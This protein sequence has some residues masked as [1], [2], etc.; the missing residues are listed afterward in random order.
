MRPFFP[1]SSSLVPFN[2][3]RVKLEGFFC[4]VFKS[5][6]Y[7]KIYFLNRNETLSSYILLDFHPPDIQELISSSIH[8]P[9]IYSAPTLYWHHH[10]NN[11]GK[12]KPYCRGRQRKE[13]LKHLSLGEPTGHFRKHGMSRT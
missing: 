4:F 13:E 7:D 9:N 11:Q 1:I 3:Q 6:V 10:V 12:N 8:S 2:L 5:Q